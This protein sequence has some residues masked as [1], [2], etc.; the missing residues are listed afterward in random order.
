[1]IIPLRLEEVAAMPVLVL[2]RCRGKPLIRT[3]FRGDAVDGGQTINR[4]GSRAGARSGLIQHE[5]SLCPE[6]PLPACRIGVFLMLIWLAF[7]MR[8]AMA[9]N[10]QH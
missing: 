1:M 4:M 8:N 2:T 6:I 10:D 5:A 7:G 9:N 3:F